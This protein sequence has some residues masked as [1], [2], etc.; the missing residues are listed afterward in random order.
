MRPDDIDAYGARFTG[1]LG[2]WEGDLATG[3]VQWSGDIDDILGLPRHGTEPSL[4]LFLQSIVPEEREG[5][6]EALRGSITNRFDHHH[7]E[8]RCRRPDGREVVVRNEWSVECDESGKP[9]LLR[10]VIQDVTLRRHAKAALTRQTALLELLYAVATRANAADTLE[11][12]LQTALD[13]ICAFGGWPAGHVYLV[14]DSEPRDLLPTSVWYAADGPRFAALRAAAEHTRVAPGVG[15][16]GHVARLGMPYWSADLRS[17]PPLPTTVAAM[18]AGIRA[19]LC[20]PV[21]VGTETVAVLELFASD[22]RAPDQMLMAAMNHVGTQLGGIFERKRSADALRES[23]ARLRQILESMPIGVFVMDAQGRPYFSNTYAR[24]INRPEPS[25]RP[26]PDRPKGPPSSDRI[27]V[28][29]HDDAYIAG[30]D[31]PYPAARHPL[32]RALAKESSVVADIEIRPPGRRIPLEVWGSPVFD[33]RGRVAYALSAFYDIS[34]RKKVERMKDEFVSVVSHELRTPLT[35][36]QGA[37]GLLESGVLGPLSDEALEMARIARDGCGR[38]LRL[39][40]EL[41]DIQKLELAKPTVHP[42]PL[43]LGPILEAAVAASRPYAA[44][45]GVR[46][47]LEDG[48]PGAVVL[49]ESDRLS[50]VVTNLLSNAIKYTPEGERVR[51]TA[52][53][54]AGR[55]RVTVEDHGPGVPEEFRGSLFQKFSQADASDNRQKGG[56]GLGLAICKMILEKLDGTVAYEPVAEGG[57]RFYF[58]LPELLRE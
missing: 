11:Q 7:V 2:F 45:L 4:A 49:A 28:G 41:L 42:Q 55:V 27:P 26:D 6:A 12:A 35:S 21:L 46:L 18:A 19:A 14:A 43:A 24:S 36:I 37:I 10:G 58:E 8:Y 5:V 1:A 53:R 56:T 25:S 13:R 32:Q 44:A 29:P 40:N 51:I 38:L 57:A 16:P 50:Q 54:G 52:T 20:V 33:E 15:M 9:T 3:T 34:E 48:A 23:E 39:V 17:Q 31:Q 30:T 22:D 47:D